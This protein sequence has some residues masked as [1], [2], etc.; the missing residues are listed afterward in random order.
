MSNISAPIIG[1][2]DLALRYIEFVRWRGHPVCPHCGVIDGHHL[3]K[4][5]RKTTTGRVSRRRTWI[6]HTC[7]RQFSVL[8]GTRL[9]GTKIPLHI[10]L[11]LLAD[12]H[13]GDRPSL[14]TIASRYGVTMQAAIRAKAAVN[15]ALP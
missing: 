6:C 4:S 5:R 10:W 9:Q 14:R 12:F 15:R 11:A 1:D 13:A 7:R 2:E 8:V 3:V